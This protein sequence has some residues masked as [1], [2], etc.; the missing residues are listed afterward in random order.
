M[1][2]V[3]TITAI[4]VALCPIALQAQSAGTP[5]TVAAPAPRGAPRLIVAISVDQFSA[6]LFAQ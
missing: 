1:K 5:P 4:A 6:D 3:A 2:T